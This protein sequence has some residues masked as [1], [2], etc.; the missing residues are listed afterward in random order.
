MDNKIP[1]P[2]DPDNYRGFPNLIAAFA[3]VGMI[4]ALVLLATGH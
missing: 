3:I 4:V 2:L 1:E